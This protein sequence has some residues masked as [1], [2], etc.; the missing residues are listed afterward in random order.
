[1]LK[2]FLLLSLVCSSFA[3]TQVF[4]ESGKIAVVDMAQLIN[5]SSQIQALNKEE[6][7]RKTEIINIIN[8]ANTE[9]QNQNNDAKKKEIATKYEKQINAKREAMTKNRKAKLEAINKNISDTIAQQAKMLGYDLVVVKGVVLYGGD[10]ITD[11]ILK[12]LK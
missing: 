7:T 5:K 6:N 8:K 11:K 2:K 10:D 3:F 4:A 9:I 12:N 1:M